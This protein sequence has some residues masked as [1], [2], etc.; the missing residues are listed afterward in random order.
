MNMHAEMQK[1]NRR[2]ESVTM[3]LR[4]WRMA[5]GLTQGQLA[6]KAGFSRSTIS[7]VE[8]GMYLPSPA[9]AASVCRALSRELGC[10]VNTWD[11]FPGVFRRPPVPLGN[12]RRFFDDD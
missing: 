8:T 4:E 12:R 10:R 9:L 5:A 6:K 7:H 2:M 11:I 3:D 1:V